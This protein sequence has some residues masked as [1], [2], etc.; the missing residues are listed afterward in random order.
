MS[1]NTLDQTNKSNTSSKLNRRGFLNSG[2]LAGVAAL[3]LF[4]PRA[5]VATSAAPAAFPA[6]KPF[7][8]SEITVAKLQD[9][10]QSGQ[11][12]ARSLAEKYLTRIENVDKHG[13]AVNS[14]IEVN[15]DALAIAAELDR[16]AKP[17]GRADRCMASPS[18]SM[19]TS[20]PATG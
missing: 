13:P 12:A 20:P 3:P 7:E 9:E 5:G 18:A 6:L 11:L 17:R 2:M 1:S 4:S 14:V 8:L 15:P 10:M 16:S 19:T